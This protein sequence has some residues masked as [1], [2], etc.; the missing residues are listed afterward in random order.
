MA[1]VG[2]KMDVSGRPNCPAAVVGTVHDCELVLVRDGHWMA[3]M[4]A[5]LPDGGSITDAAALINGRCGAMRDPDWRL[6]DRGGVLEGDAWK[7]DDSRIGAVEAI[8]SHNWFMVRAHHRSTM[9][10]RIEYW[11]LAMWCPSR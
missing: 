11:F 6:D 8:E 2:W 1:G 4:P 7:L 10:D 3:W 9:S 5:Q